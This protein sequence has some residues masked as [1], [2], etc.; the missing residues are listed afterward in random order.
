MNSEFIK[1]ILVAAVAIP[2][3]IFATVWDN[4]W[5]FAVGLYVVI[6]LANRELYSMLRN[7]GEPVSAA[8]SWFGALL[9]PVCFYFNNSWMLF[10]FV[11]TGLIFVIF[12]MKM[13][14]DEPTVGVIRY[15]SVN[16]FAAV[17]LPFLLSFILMVRLAPAGAMWIIFVFVAIWA[18]DS[19][20][21]IVGS[22]FGKRKIVPKVSPKKSLEGFIAGLFFGILA[23]IAFYYVAIHDVARL[24]VLKIVVIAIDIVLAG[25]LG[26]LFESM[27]KRDAGVKDS[28][29]LIPGH[30]GIFDRMDSLVFAVPILYMY[31][32]A[33][34]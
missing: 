26:D 16:M 30:G 13:F 6:L 12:L 8:V 32:M 15:V 28:G 23:G 24:S 19:M 33:W 10:A 5:P 7:A 14:T 2:V 22:K 9:I 29:N 1:R 11:L 27:L 25:I 20:A 17:F 3:V 18:S 4:T 21:Y 31:L 34:S